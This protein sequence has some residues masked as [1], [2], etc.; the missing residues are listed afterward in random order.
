MIEKKRVVDCCRMR[1]NK[2][3]RGKV[4]PAS[5]ALRRLGVGVALEGAIDVLEYA[6][7]SCMMFNVD[8]RT[9]VMTSTD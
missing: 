6:I 2:D 7:K 9:A 4:Q 5:V 3:E 1:P 8:V